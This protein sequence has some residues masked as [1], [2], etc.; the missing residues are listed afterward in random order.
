MAKE[1]NHMMCQMMKKSHWQNSILTNVKNSKTNKARKELLQIH[2][3]Y[4]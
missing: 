3:D 4:Q 1:E 2:N